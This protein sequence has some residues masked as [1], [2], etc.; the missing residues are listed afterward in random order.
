MCCVV[1]LILQ[2]GIPVQ[3]MVVLGGFNGTEYLNATALFVTYLL[4]NYVA[5]EDNMPA[6]LWESALLQLLKTQPLRDH[7]LTIVYS[8]EAIFTSLSLSFVILFFLLL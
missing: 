4:N 3:P 6:M 8:T 5:V 1:L 7:N 2:I